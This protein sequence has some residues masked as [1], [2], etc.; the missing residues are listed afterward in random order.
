MLKKSNLALNKPQAQK[1]WLESQDYNQTQILQ[2]TYSTRL[3]RAEPLFV[4]GCEHLSCATLG[5]RYKAEDLSAPVLE[6]LNKENVLLHAS[7]R[8][9]HLTYHNLGQLVVYPILDLNFFNLNLRNFVCLLIQSTQELLKL[10]GLDST[11][12]EKMSGL[13][14]EGAKIMSLGLRVQ[15]GKVRHGFALNVRNDLDVFSRLEP[16]GHSEM[17]LTSMKRILKNDL[18]PSELFFEWTEIFLKR[19]YKP[20]IAQIKSEMDLNL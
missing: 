8:G 1:F 3:S 7:D 18:E 4:L 9:G 5:Y 2:K 10:Y 11:S 15:S 13:F 16:C 6:T 20:S 12:N 14:I 17:M 19:L